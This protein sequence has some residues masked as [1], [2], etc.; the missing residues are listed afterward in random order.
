MSMKHHKMIV[1]LDDGET[2]TEGGYIVS[3]TEEAYKEVCE[4]RKPSNIEEGAKVITTIGGS[5]D[6]LYPDK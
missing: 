2:W 3:L 1:V 4:G 5:T 6:R